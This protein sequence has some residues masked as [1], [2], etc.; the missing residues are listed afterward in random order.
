MHDDDSNDRSRVRNRL[1]G[2]LG[3]KTI[4]AVC[5]GILLGVISGQPKAEFIRRSG[6]RH[7][8]YLRA[9][10]NEVI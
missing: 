7:L 6:G 9:I 8:G 5:F 2:T 1:R 3:A 10:L 4:T